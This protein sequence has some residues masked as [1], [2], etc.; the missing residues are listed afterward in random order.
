MPGIVKESLFLFKKR[1]GKKGPEV[2]KNSIT[3]RRF[4][5]LFKRIFDVTVT[6]LVT[7]LVLSW[8]IPLLAL[9]IKLDSKGPVFFI[10]K[11]VGFL[12]RTFLCFKL[13]T[14][15][16]NTMCDDQQALANDP[17]ITRL[18]KFLRLSSLD[19]LPQF[20]NVLKGDMSIVGPRPHMHKDNADFSRIVENYRLR[21]LVKPGITGMAQVKGFRGPAQDFHQ[22]FHRY[23]W[24]AFYIRNANL[25]LDFKIMRLTA[26]QVVK[27]LFASRTREIQEETTSGLV[28]ARS[29][30]K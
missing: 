3:D 23:Q 1:N 17:R 14:M 10:Q 6:L 18:G 13:R 26:G 15:Y 5:L 22:I 30:N 29:A 27:S 9:I 19:E 4:Y 25:S 7:I 8:L 16:V 21:Y 12:G 2:S 24:D 20:F 28:F 11:R